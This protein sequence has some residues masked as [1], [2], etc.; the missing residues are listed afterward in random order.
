[1]RALAIS[2]AGAL[3]L[4]FVRNVSL[5]RDAVGRRGGSSNRQQKGRASAE[6]F[7]PKEAP[8]GGRSKL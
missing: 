7:S 1:M 2:S 4:L 3:S 8:A 6:W 5:R